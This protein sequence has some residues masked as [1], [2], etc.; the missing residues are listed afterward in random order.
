MKV[1]DN[2][3]NSKVIKIKRNQG[4]N[5]NNLMV[6]P[7]FS[8]KKGKIPTMERKWIRGDM[9]VGITVVGGSRYGVPT[10]Y[11]LDTLLALFRLNM[12]KEDNNIY[13]EDGIVTNIP[14]VI[15]FSYRKLAN[16]MNLT[17]SMPTKKRL[18]G[19]IHCLIETTIYS[20]FG[21]RNQCEGKYVYDFK[22]EESCR[23]IKNYK[24][25]SVTKRKKANEE[26]IA[27]TQIED[28][29]SIEIDDFFYENMCN[30]YFKLYDYNK[31]NQLTKAIAKKLFLLLS[32]WS[33]GYEKFLNTQTIYDY[34]GLDI[35][36]SKDKYYYN[37]LIKESLKE[38]VKVK[39]INDY[40]IDKRGVTF[41]FNQSLLSK[42]RNLKK[43]NNDNPF[44]VISRL[45]EIG[46]DYDDI[47]TYYTSDT[48]E[49]IEAL[50]R[51]VDYLESLGKISKIKE[52]VTKGLVYNSY[53]VDKFKV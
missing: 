28:Y 25:Y 52:F 27:P 4:L 30:N 39:F 31:Y 44:E 23:I 49:Y 9:E 1:V 26:L 46:I 40:S 51:Y 19:Y 3:D 12:K 16:E 8:L 45:R 6:L 13:I 14:K 17:Y 53:D 22:G 50:L 33:H 32:T 47:F 41:I 35:N 2:V 37:R 34:L 7:I 48:K 43:Y 10:I 20:D 11:C 5:E 18:E 42:E 21:L 24:S 29:Q 36:T 38:L 15:N